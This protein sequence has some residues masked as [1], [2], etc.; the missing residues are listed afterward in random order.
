MGKG[1]LAFNVFTGTKSLPIQNADIKVKD[2]NGNTLY[3]LKTNENGQTEQVALDTID[4]GATLDPN[5]SGIPYKIYVAEVVAEGYISLIIRGV[6]I[7]DTVSSILPVNMMPLLSVKGAKSSTIINIP[8]NNLLNSKKR[9]QEAPVKTPKILEDVII[10]NTIKVHLGTP[11]SSA[12]NIE[13]PFIDYVKNV[14]SS[15]IYPSWP[16]NAIIAN[17]HAQISFALNRIY[18]EWYPTKGYSFNITNVPAYDQYFVPGRNIFDNISEI[19][20]EIFNVYI[21]RDGRKEPYISQF[22]NGTTSTCSG[23]S[24]WGTVTLANEGYNPIN[25]LKYYY[26]NDIELV[27]SYLFEDLEE[28]YPGYPLKVGSK[29]PDVKTMQDYLNRIRINF[30]L[31][32]EISNPNGEF[33]TDMEKSVKVFQKTFGIQADGIIG[34][35]TWFEISRIYG[36]V[37]KLSE[38]DSE[39]QII[40]IPNNK[41]TSVIRRGDKGTDVEILQYLLNYISEFYNFVPSVIQNSSFDQRTE[42]SVKE[43]QR[44]FGLVSDGIVGPST[45]NK[46]YE[47]YYSIQENVEIPVVELPDGGMEYK[48]Y[49]GYLLKVGVRG[50]DVKYMQQLMNDISDVYTSIPKLSEDGIFGEG[51]KQGVIAF[52]KQFGLVADGIVGNSTW[53]KMIEV[54]KTLDNIILDVPY[55]GN[56]LKRG[57]RG[58]DVKLMQEYLNVISTVYTS[59][60][61]LDTDGIFGAGTERGVIA[62][63]KEFGLVA[64]GIIGPS[65]WNRI[66]DEHNKIVYGRYTRRKSR[67]KNV[68]KFLLGSMFFNGRV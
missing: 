4:K 14:A 54:H 21:R 48:E 49:P 56:I 63:Q 51:T 22:C 9:I 1:Y 6:Q 29:G 42:T 13:V 26:P 35:S 17:M 12:Q 44:N 47:V 18:T 28:S 59:I 55:P 24:Q 50:D 8:E 7:F 15:E 65:T 66:V 61:K 38:L 62:F 27:Q 16:R 5:F 34:K 36:A 31:I 33:G 25:I 68:N 67:D 57:S 23:L 46:L 2:I 37:K 3:T 60:P 30:P 43:F 10:P 58:D 52:Q 53:N 11:S 32:P 39:G 41:P 20:D 40:D 19:A 45:W 64:D